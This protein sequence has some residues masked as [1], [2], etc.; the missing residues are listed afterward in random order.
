MNTS[1]ARLNGLRLTFVALCTI[2]GA[3]AGFTAVAA[4][5]PPSREPNPIENHIVTDTQGSNPCG[6]P[7]LL[8]V[9]TN[10]EIVTTFERKSGVTVLNVTGALKVR[11]TNTDTDKS[12]ERNISGPTHL[13]VN[14]DGSITQ[15]TS[16][17]GLWAFDPGVALGLPRMAITKGRT[18]S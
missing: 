18:V 2:L 13:T 9:I 8:E 14:S 7:V 5:E 3:G 15:E 10:K 1:K 6:F 11:L 12:I 4:A 17:P 16:G